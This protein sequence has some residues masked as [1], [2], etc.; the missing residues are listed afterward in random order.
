MKKILLL[1]IICTS[2]QSQWKEIYAT[3]DDET[4]GTGDNTTDVIVLGE[5]KFVALC[6][7]RNTTCYLIPYVGADSAL[8]RKQFYGY[9]PATDGIFQKWI[10]GFDEVELKNA[11]HATSGNDGSIYVANNDS[12]HNILVFKMVGDTIDAIDYRLETGKNGISGIAV[13]SLGFVYV[14]NDTT[15]GKN[16]DIKIYPPKSQWPNTRLLNPIKTINLPDGIYKSL[17]VTQDGNQIFIAD[18]L[19]RKILRY[20]GFP[21]SGYSLDS[22]FK[23]SVPAT[24]TNLIGV[25]YDTA[26][27][28]SL[29]YLKGKN[30]LFA[31]LNKFLGGTSWYKYSKIYTINPNTGIV[32]DTINQAKWNFDLT[33]GYN[34]RGNGTVPGNA[35]G[36]A[37]PYD[38]EF[39]NKNNLYTVSYYGW[40]VE[41][42]SYD[43]ILPTILSVKEIPNLMPRNFSIE[44]NFP[45][46]FNPV[47]TI[48]FSIL[49]NDNISITIKNILGQTIL[50]PLNEKIKIGVHELTLDMSKQPSGNYFYSISNGKEIITKKMML[51][52]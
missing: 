32:L 33:G 19:N 16:D 13:D 15:N 35:S 3:Y 25:I 44:Q 30:L 51:V 38:I 27:V 31:G 6:T 9:S 26:Y 37:S 43:G 22:K 8:G 17:V 18:Y 34:K 20:I 14:L 45:N 21:N 23:F 28:V 39:D 41:K 50:T 7:Q 49:E 5:N 46:P 4:N 29:G 36:Y 2:L 47:T 42:W 52:K 10:Q 48:R 1:L 40:T 11:W 24:D 12:L